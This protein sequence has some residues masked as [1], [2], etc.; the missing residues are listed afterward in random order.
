MDSEL[1]AGKTALGLRGNMK[2][3]LGQMDDQNS[4]DEF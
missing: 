1:G 3:Q 2:Q 4:G